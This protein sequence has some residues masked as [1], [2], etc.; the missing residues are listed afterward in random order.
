MN[1]N[2]IGIAIGA[3][4]TIFVALYAGTSLAEGTT[5]PVI[6]LGGIVGTIILVSLKEK[7]WFPLII[8]PFISY[9]LPFSIFS[10]LTFAELALIVTTPFIAFNIFLGR[11]QLAWRKNPFLDLSFLGFFILIIILMIRYPIGLGLDHENNFMGTRTYFDVMLAAFAYLLLSCLKID[12]PNFKKILY[13]GVF[14]WLFFCLLGSFN[15]LL[16]YGDEISN[17]TISGSRFSALLNPGCWM[18]LFCIS[19]YGVTT[20][21]RKPWLAITGFLGLVFVTLS[22]FRNM[23]ANLGLSFFFVSLINRRY[24][25]LFLAPVIA[26]IG[27]F[28]IIFS[29]GMDSLP[30]GIQRSISFLPF[31]EVDQEITANAAH[32]TEWRITMWKWALDEKENYIKDK[33]FGDGFAMEK[34]EHFR[35]NYA[36][37]LGDQEEFATRGLWHSGPISTIHRMGIIGLIIVLLILFGIGYY[38][39]LICKSFR[40]ESYAWIVHMFFIPL[41]GIPVFWIFIFGEIRNIHAILFQLGAIKFVFNTAKEFSFYQ[42]TTISQRKYIP[43]MID[44]NNN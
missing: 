44:K 43:L 40:N 13:I 11:I 32:S 38:A 37:K 14:S 23:L 15:T 4:I 24:L 16:G 21:L 6:I 31:V 3:I 42:P 39:Y 19:R 34:D 7:V 5:T 26:A 17:E 30:M 35:F 41:V 20:M 25:D 9:S 1:N 2:I 28:V 29:L 22:G 18:V 12:I 33:I 27:L 10:K 8:A 36:N